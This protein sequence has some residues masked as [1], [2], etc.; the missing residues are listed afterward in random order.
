M[1]LQKLILPVL[2]S[3]QF[4]QRK[5][6]VCDF[7]K[8]HTAFE[9]KKGMQVA[10]KK[11]SRLKTRESNKK[12]LENGRKEVIQFDKVDEDYIKTLSLYAKCQVLP[13]C[14]FWAGI[15]SLEL[16]KFTGKFIPIQDFYHF[17]SFECLSVGENILR[18]PTGSRYDDQIVLFG[19]DAQEKLQKMK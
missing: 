2:Q 18:E 13:F 19:K 8:C 11:E 4:C 5:G 14:A 10:T 17:D 3:P 6:L 16:V 9:I 15:I 1:R 7:P 12:M